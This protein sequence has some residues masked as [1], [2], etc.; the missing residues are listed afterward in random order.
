L[1]PRRSKKKRRRREKRKH[2]I[3]ESPVSED[4]PFASLCP[5]RS[6]GRDPIGAR[7][8]QKMKILPQK[9]QTERTN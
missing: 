2:T 6:D 9:R 8:K 7:L 1:R 3:V 4:T 5:K